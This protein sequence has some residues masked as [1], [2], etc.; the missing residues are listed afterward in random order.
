MAAKSKKATKG[1][2]AR[3]AAKAGKPKSAPPIPPGFHTVT[4]ILVVRGA[5]KAIEFWKRAFGAKERFRM[6]APDGRI[7]H[8]EIQV[9]SS[10]LML[11]DEFPERGSLAPAGGANPPVNFYLYVTDC[12][13]VFQQATQA[14]C[15]VKMPLMDM[16][17]G[18][19]FGTL[20]DPFGHVWSVATHKRDV[21]PEE[22]A[23]AAK[24]Q[25]QQQPQPQPQT[26]GS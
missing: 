12:D 11:S 20:Q 5:A 8:A 9:G 7:G 13:K 19:R 18:D 1:K 17:W 15:T 3:P 2:K 6:D 14:G 16:F 22:M 10:I 26:V 23:K 25:M 4:P 21:S 24:E